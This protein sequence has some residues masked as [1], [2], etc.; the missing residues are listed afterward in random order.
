MT[1]TVTL[2]IG[3][4]KGL[5]LLRPDTARDSWTVDG[6]HC[7][8]WPINHSA[9]DPATGTLWA[10]GGGDWHGAG[11]WRSTDDGASWTLAKLADGQMDAW[12]RADPATAQML[13]VTP[14]D[15]GPYTG[16][17]DALWS[18]HRAGGRLFAGGK[19]GMLFVSADDGTTWDEVPGFN[20]HPTREDWGPG[21]V[22]LTLHTLTSDPAN[23]DRLWLA[24]SAAGVFAS[25]DGGTTWE[26]RNRLA[27]TGAQLHAHPHPAAPCNGDTGLCVHNMVRAPGTPDTLYQ[28]NHHGVFRSRDGGRSWSDITDGLPSTFGF[29]IAVHPQDADTLWTFPLNGDTAG[30]FP[31]DAAA[32]VWRS[33]DGGES[34]KPCRTGLPQ[35]ACHFTVLRQGMAT[36]SHAA[37]GLY[38]GTNTGSVFASLDGA[39]SWREIARHLPTIL[40]VETLTR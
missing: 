31:P 8:L 13:G 28:Q 3:T 36:D 12:V 24:V 11:V 29:P 9:A 6:P 20:A 22:G 30:R 37:P 27:N 39:D 19:P 16:Q 38:F 15:P 7:E 32:A 14:A 10:A 21:A 2:L 1:Q 40:S 18:L 4:T 23:P 33:R 34:W 35:T 25:E 5:F 17:L 26:R